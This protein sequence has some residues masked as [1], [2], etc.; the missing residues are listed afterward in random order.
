[1]ESFLSNSDFKY[2]ESLS[3]ALSYASVGE[4]VECIEKIIH[5]FISKYEK[6]EIP[7][8]TYMKAIN[9]NLFE[10]NL[11]EVDI[12]KKYNQLIDLSAKQ[13]CK[14]ALYI[15]ACRLYECE[16]FS[17]A[18]ELYKK[19]M[20]KGYPPAMW[21]YG[22]DRFWG[23]ENVLAKDAAEG[24]KYIKLSAGLLYEYALEFLLD[25]YENGKET[26]E[27][28]AEKADYYRALLATIDE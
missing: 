13:G 15:K 14:E 23:I 20:H 7:E 19:S 11:S 22:L 25:A 26:I 5:T 9:L 4:N 27:K 18:I 10:K 28:D 17:E 24:L 6:E 8:I 16:E 3:E 2:L 1:M 12:E 21:C